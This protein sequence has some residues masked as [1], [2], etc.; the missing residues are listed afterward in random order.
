MVSFNNRHNLCKS[1][2]C[3]I[4]DLWFS[5]F[6]EARNWVSEYLNFDI[7]RDV[8]LFEVTIRILGGLLSAYHLSADKVFLQ[9]SVC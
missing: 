9:K 3:F 8:N 5:E 2:F 4:F 6:A 7:N 1:E